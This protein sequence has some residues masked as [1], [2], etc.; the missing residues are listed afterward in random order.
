[1]LY[2]TALLRRGPDRFWFS[3]VSLEETRSVVGLDRFDG[4]FYGSK[5]YHLTSVPYVCW[6][7]NSPAAVWFETR[8]VTR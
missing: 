6:V 3:L 1:M 8:N 2:L 5:I 4:L 7:H